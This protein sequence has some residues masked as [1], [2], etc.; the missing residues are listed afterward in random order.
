MKLLYCGDCEDVVA[1]RTT[2]RHCH[3]GKVCA[4]YTGQGNNIDWNG[5]GAIL[6]IDSEAL[7]VQYAGHVMSGRFKEMKIVMIRPD[8]STIRITRNLG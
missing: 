8:S 4:K 5:S 3:C 7:A 1:L 6:G 2:L